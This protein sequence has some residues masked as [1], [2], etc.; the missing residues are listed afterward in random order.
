[1]NR[2]FMIADI[3]FWTPWWSR[4]GTDTRHKGVYAWHGTELVGAKPVDMMSHGTFGELDEPWTP[5]QGMVPRFWARDLHAKILAPRFWCRG[6]GT[7][8]LVPDARVPNLA[9]HGTKYYL[10]R[11]FWAQHVR[12]FKMDQHRMNPQ[13]FVY[14]LR[15]TNSCLHGN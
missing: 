7:E 10:T 1:M 8:I 9:R 2:I 5:C 4:H 3:I 12:P 6:S 14:H 13:L 11:H 15:P